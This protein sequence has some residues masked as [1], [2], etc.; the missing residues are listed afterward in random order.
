[1]IDFNN[2]NRIHGIKMTFDLTDAFKPNFAVI[3]KNRCFRYMTH[4]LLAI[5]N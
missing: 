1:M 2:Y 4:V 3:V 5:M